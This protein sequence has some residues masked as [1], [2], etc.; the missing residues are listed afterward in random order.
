[1]AEKIFFIEQFK[2]Q[3]L[4]TVGI[5]SRTR[6]YLFAL[7]IISISSFGKYGEHQG[8]LYKLTCNAS[9]QV[10]L[11][12]FNCDQLW[13][14]NTIDMND[15]NNDKSYSKDVYS[16]IFYLCFVSFSSYIFVINAVKVWTQVGQCL[17]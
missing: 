2:W 16:L 9:V 7:L 10:L 12:N 8:E 15:Y 11:R 5:L 4:S 1:M 14:H 17:L 3:S 6:P 13:F